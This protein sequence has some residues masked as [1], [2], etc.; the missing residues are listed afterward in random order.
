MTIVFIVS[1]YAIA[2][3][4]NIAARLSG[5]SNQGYY[6]PLLLLRLIGRSREGNFIL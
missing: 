1:R 6:M 4:L 5:L 2:H 3:L